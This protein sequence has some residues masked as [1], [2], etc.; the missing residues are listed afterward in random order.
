M[1]DDLINSIKRS[2]N[3]IEN[4]MPKIVFET[5]SDSKALI[6]NRIVGSGEI[7]KG[8]KSNYKEGYYKKLRQDKGRQVGHKDYRFTG[9]MWGSIQAI[10]ST[11]KENGNYFYQVDL[12]ALDSENQKKLKYN[13]ERDGVNILSNT[14]EEE[15]KLQKF[16]E[17]KLK[18]I[19][20]NNL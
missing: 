20:D 17:N 13:N 4:A 10:P 18:R 14:K 15:K 11:L 19:L 16:I 12:D 8:T 5:A 7:A 9:A 6:Q 3:Q 1:I 2:V